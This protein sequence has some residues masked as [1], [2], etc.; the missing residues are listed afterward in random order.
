[1]LTRGGTLDDG[2][3][4]NAGPPPGNDDALVDHCALNGLF[5]LRGSQGLTRSGDGG[6]DGK[7][8]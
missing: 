5:G 7:E 2:S 4:E 6:F 1:M 3:G 8:K